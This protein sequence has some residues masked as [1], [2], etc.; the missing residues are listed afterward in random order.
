MVGPAFNFTEEGRCTLA[1][2]VGITHWLCILPSFICLLTALYIQILIE[3]KISFIENYDGMVLPGFLV[4]SGFFGF[5]AHI[6]CGKVAYTNRIPAKREKWSGFILAAII[7]TSVIF[8][9]E[10]ISGIMCFVHIANLEDSLDSGIRVAMSAYKN[11]AT[12][13][14]K[15]DILQMTYECCGSRSYKDWFYLT[16]IHPDYV[17][18][19]TTNFKGRG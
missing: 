1:K 6:V 17:N 2:F 3:D 19:N 4:F 11:D 13:K 16:W 8:L 18:V 9:S 12:T 14:E 7:A 5:F 10:F 15:T